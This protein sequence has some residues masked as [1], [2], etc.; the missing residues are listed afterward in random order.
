MLTLLE[1]LLRKKRR[2][3]KNSNPHGRIVGI[4]D[5]WIFLQRPQMANLRFSGYT[6]TETLCLLLTRR[7]I[8]RVSDI[9]VV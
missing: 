9:K 6:S 3:F 8:K 2:R 5:K 1:D 7:Y 4:T